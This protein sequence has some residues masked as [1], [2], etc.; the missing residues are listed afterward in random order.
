M[1]QPGV[2]FGHTTIYPFIAEKA[3]PLSKAIL[4]DEGLTFEAHSTDYQS[5]ESLADLVKN[6]FFFL[7]VGPELTFRF[8]EAVWA[9]AQIEETLDFDQPSNIR[10][11]FAKRMV[12]NPEFWQD[13]YSGSAHELSILRTYSYSD[14][15]RYYWP[16]RQI[17][18][19]LER[20]LENLSM[21]T[22]PKTVVS[23]AFICLLYK[24][25]S[26]RD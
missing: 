25:P 8:R 22:A 16:D 6:H 3:Y 24:S 20:L 2:D 7:K 18:L 21:D 1:T 4:A 15:I 11:I 5:T 13:Y 9:L 26:P 17:V 12:E 23:Q 14:R 19:A 10:D